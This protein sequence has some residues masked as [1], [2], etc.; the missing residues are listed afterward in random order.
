MKKPLLSILFILYLSIQSYSS[1][2][3]K[4]IFKSKDIIPVSTKGTDSVTLIFN[5]SN[6]NKIFKNY[7]ISKF[8]K[9]YPIADSFPD[10]MTSAVQLRLVYQVRV[11][12]DLKDKIKKLKKDIDSTNSPDIDTAIQTNDPIVLSTPPNDYYNCFACTTGNWPQAHHHLDLINAL[13]A[14]D[15]TKGLSCIKI[16]LS[17]INFQHHVDL[18]NKVNITSITAPIAPASSNSSHGIEVAGMAGAETNNN[19]GISSLGYNIRLNY[20]TSDYNGIVNAIYD[21]CKVVNCSWY[22]YYSSSLDLPPSDVQNV[23]TLAQSNNVT[24]VAAAGNNNSGTPT[25][26]FYPASYNGVISVTA[27]GSQYNVGD[28][29]N[30]NWKDCHREFTNPND[31][32]YNHTYQHNDRV[33]I[34]A[35]GYYIETTVANNNYGN[36]GGTFFAAPL[37]SAAAA[38][39]Y[40]INPFFTPSE[41]EGYI[42]NNAAN[43]YGVYDNYLWTGKLGAGRL[44]AQ[45]SVKAALTKA[46]TANYCNSC[47]LENTYLTDASNSV[48]GYFYNKNI[49]AGS[50]NSNVVSTSNSISTTLVA[51]SS[52]VLSPEFDAVATANISFSARIEP[53][54][55]VAGRAISNNVTNKKKEEFKIYPNPTNNIIII[56]SSLFYKGQ[57]NID[58]INSVGVV[59]RRAHKKTDA[60]GVDK[61]EIDVKG[62]PSGLYYV[63]I[64]TGA[65]QYNNKFIK[66]SK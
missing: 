59:V 47:P 40:S 57:V 18:D 15:I 13:S 27:V 54:T 45:A 10:Y 11:S 42:K 21:G 28:P 34:C 33:D 3:L 39:L 48:S 1:G 4:I 53:C 58:V 29:S 8:E 31:P 23:L 32:N 36:D 55:I 19:T 43:I 66:I 6:L 51:T 9:E 38:L 5:D 26:Y 14:W 25:D 65:K 20:Y 64:R 30:A 37:V 44:D 60:M 41:I 22:I 7:K 63:I 52:I 61:T 16:G 17:D 24:I 46:Y 49:Y 35:P 56:A 2:Y 12:G 62:L 50:N